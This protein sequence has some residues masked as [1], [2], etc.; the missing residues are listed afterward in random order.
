MTKQRPNVNG[1]PI[2]GIGTRNWFTSIFLIV[3]FCIIG[4]IVI[5]GDP[6]N[7]LHTSALSWS[8]FSA[9]TVLFMHLFAAN[10]SEYV[11]GKEW[12]SKKGKDDN[13]NL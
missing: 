5:D 12:L 8:F 4:Y 1:I 3:L 6:K 11:V 2:P 13:A 7:S 9:I 10:V